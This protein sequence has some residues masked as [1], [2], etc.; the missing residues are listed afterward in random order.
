M[1]RETDGEL[2]EQ[3]MD[4]KLRV[5]YRDNLGKWQYSVGGLLREELAMDAAKRV[6]EQQKTITRIVDELTGQV[7]GLVE[8]W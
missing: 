5:D 8:V 6:S 2:R 1:L 7:R 4:A 3:H